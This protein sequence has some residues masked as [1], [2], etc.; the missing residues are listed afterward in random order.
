MQSLDPFP[1][2]LLFKSLK[3]HFTTEKYDYNKYCGKVSGDTIANKQKFMYNKQRYFFARL[4][5]HKDPPGLL[6]SNFI[7]DPKC[8]ITEI[9]DDS[10]LARFE[11]YVARN[12]SR[13]Y[14]LQ[15]DL[16]K[17]DS[18]KELLTI[19]S[20]P[21]II[22][23]YISEDI[24]PESVVLIDSVTKILDKIDDQCHPLVEKHLLKLRKYRSFVKTD[25]EKVKAVFERQWTH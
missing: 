16:K 17:F 11:Q 7:R 8:F 3:L 22:D 25:V 24:A 18:I 19:D 13:Y 20:Y 6:V 21:A 14:T 2:S 12:A 9:V 1:A 4:G 10:G 5:R 23:K 15:Q